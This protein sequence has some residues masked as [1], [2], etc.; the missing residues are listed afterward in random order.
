[1]IETTELFLPFFVLSVLEEVGSS[2]FSLFS[3]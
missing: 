3:D 2:L 1:M